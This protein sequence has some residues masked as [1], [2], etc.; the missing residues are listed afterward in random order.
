MGRQ[1]RHISPVRDFPHSSRKKMVSFW[2][3]NKFDIDL[4]YSSKILKHLCLFPLP[5]CWF[6]YHSG[7]SASKYAWLNIGEGEGTFQGGKQCEVEIS[8]LFQ[9]I[10]EKRC[11]F[12]RFVTSIVAC[13]VKTAV[14]SLANIEPLWPHAWSIM[15]VFYHLKVPLVKDCLTV[16]LQL[17]FFLFGKPALAAATHLLEDC[18]LH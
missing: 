4:Q 18:F 5:Q 17:F 10:R 8:W 7:L 3:Y 14:Y 9:K 11:L 2:P 6:G 1:D 15:H 13:S 16:P 12:Q